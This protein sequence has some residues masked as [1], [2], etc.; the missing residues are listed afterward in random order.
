ML[1][2]ALLLFQDVVAW[3]AAGE[4]EER[5]SAQVLHFLPRARRS[6]SIKLLRSAR[7]HIVEVKAVSFFFLFVSSV[8][9]LLFGVGW[10]GKK[11]LDGGHMRTLRS[12][13]PLPWRALLLFRM[14]RY[15]DLITMNGTSAFNT[16]VTILRNEHI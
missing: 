3:M 5:Q 11:P 13:R 1:T 10:L 6:P 14:A 16:N 8:V 9:P 7:G 2:Y 4:V 12:S 15:F